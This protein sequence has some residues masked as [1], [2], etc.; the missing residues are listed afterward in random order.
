MQVTVS[1]NALADQA[2]VGIVETILPSGSTSNRTF[3]VKVLVENPDQVIKPGMFA[4]VNMAFT[5]A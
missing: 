4:N 5:E 1:F 3:T 2:F